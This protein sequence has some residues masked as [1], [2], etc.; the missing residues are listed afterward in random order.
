MAVKLFA[1]FVEEIKN[2]ALWIASYISIRLTDRYAT[3]ETSVG[4]N[5]VHELC[6]QTTTNACR[7]SEDRQDYR[8]AL[9]GSWKADRALVGLV[10][11]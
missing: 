9:V 5:T 11:S 6:M 10:S 3:Q 1:L 8:W 4:T 7:P 2:H